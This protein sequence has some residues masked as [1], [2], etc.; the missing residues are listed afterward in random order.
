M[1]GTIKFIGELYRCGLLVERI[2]HECIQHLLGN[3]ETPAE[4]DVEALCKL[5]GTIGRS[6]D[7]QKAAGYMT[8]YF[9]RLEK[10]AKNQ[11]LSSHTRYAVC[12]SDS[13]LVWID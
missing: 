2:M 12:V 9:Q 1:L 11:L 6:L 13:F 10:I 7:H 4:E 3:A 8:I 5:M